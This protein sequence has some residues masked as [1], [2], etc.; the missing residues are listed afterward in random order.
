MPSR[1]NHIWNRSLMRSLVKEG[2]NVTALSVETDKPSKNLHYI[3]LDGVN[4]KIQQM[5]NN[6]DYESISDYMQLINI[7]AMYEFFNLVCKTA[8]QSEGVKVL[9]NYPRDSFDLVIHDYTCGQCLLGF[10]NYFNNPPLISI[11]PLSTPT[12]TLFV[13]GNTHF[14]SY[15]VHPSSKYDGPMTFVQ[16]AVNLFLHAAEW[17]Y[18]TFVFM[19]HENLRAREFFGEYIVKNLESI[20]QN[21]SVV[22]TNSDPNLDM[23]HPLMPNI[24]PLAG[25]HIQKPSIKNIPEKI[26]KFLNE[27]SN[28]AV[29]FSLGNGI[30]SEL[31]SEEKIEMFLDAFGKLSEYRFVWK[32]GNESLIKKLPTNVIIHK[33]IPQNDILAHRNVRLF[34]SHAGLLSIQEAVYNAVPILGLPFFADQHKNIH[35]TSRDNVSLTLDYNTIT[36]EVLQTKIRQMLTDSSFQRNMGKL[37]ARFHDNLNTPVERA[38]HWVSYVLKHDGALHMRSPSVGMSLKKLLMFDVLSLLVLVVLI[39]AFIVY[40]IIRFLGIGQRP[41]R[42][43]D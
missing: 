4:E 16:R 10:V 23:S 12:Y 26:L 1:S 13:S 2:H 40:R 29:L 34:I 3:P 25:L 42:K 20:E 36:S 22:F 43:R 33:W 28:G 27:S 35:K 38:F 39:I 18:R 7:L 41:K 14:P 11:T 30:R 5:Y 31:M 37:S 8:L 6:V 32:F 15:M 9:L 21:T 17:M 19:R 24:I